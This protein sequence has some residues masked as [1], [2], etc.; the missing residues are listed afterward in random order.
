MA[1]GESWDELRRQVGQYESRI[2]SDLQE[3]QRISQSVTSS[4]DPKM[5]V[6]SELRAQ[7]NESFD[8]FR[9]CVDK[10][11]RRAS[12]AAQKAQ[13]QRFR[14]IASDYKQEFLRAANHLDS[15][16]ERSELF[17][18]NN[19]IRRPSDIEE[20][21]GLLDERRALGSSLD[22]VDEVLG[23]AAGTVN[24]LRNQRAVFTETMGNLGK[25]NTGIPGVE[26]LIGRIGSR[27]FV[28]SMVIGITISFCI[29]FTIWYKFF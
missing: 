17:K 21:D 19:R 6:A 16:V 3:L 28:E 11:N 27:Q 10:M 18:T 8:Q 22:M 7:L 14:D 25:I 13:I 2:E 5:T 1:T 23:S 24:S 9:S 20:G 29:C 4:S 12:G 26:R 15:Q